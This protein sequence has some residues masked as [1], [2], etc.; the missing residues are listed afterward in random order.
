MLTCPGLSR[1]RAAGR[2]LPLH[3]QPV[4]YAW[5][6]APV[7]DSNLGT[8]TVR[9]MGRFV[10]PATLARVCPSLGS[11]LVNAMALDVKVDQISL[12]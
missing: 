9:S 8:N 2:Q 11:G 1:I 12:A 3:V 5:S 7:E 10:W 6:R 4:E